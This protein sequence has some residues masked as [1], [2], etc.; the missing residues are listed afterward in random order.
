LLKVRPGITSWGQVRFG[1]ASDI[2]QMLKRMKYDLNYLENM[3]LSLDMKIL[4][5]TA[6]V[7]FQ[8]KGK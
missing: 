8:G 3:S 2:D 1:Y 4:A 7:L 6:L 5:Q